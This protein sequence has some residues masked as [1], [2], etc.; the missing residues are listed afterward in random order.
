MTKK[1]SGPQTRERAA[2]FTAT[3]GSIQK[4]AESLYG[5]PKGSVQIVDPNTGNNI[6]DD[7]KVK[8]VRKR[9]E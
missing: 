5:L 2:R 8:S 7:A 6:R 1:R 4:D 9:S 3:V